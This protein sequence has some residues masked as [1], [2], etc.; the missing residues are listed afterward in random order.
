MPRDG[1]CVCVCEQGCDH[2]QETGEQGTICL[3]NVGAGDDATIQSYVLNAIGVLVNTAASD[4]KL[5]T[6]VV[7]D[8]CTSIGRVRQADRVQVALRTVEHGQPQ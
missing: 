2:S 3:A 6:S 4:L 5:L 1:W 7:P 8:E